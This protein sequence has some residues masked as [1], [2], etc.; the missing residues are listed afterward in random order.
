MQIYHLVAVV[1][2]EHST[3]L[4]S[5]AKVIVHVMDANDQEPL[6]T[7]PELN[8][9][10]LVS[11]RLAVG[12]VISRVRASDNDIGDN[13]RLSYAFYHPDA[14]L[15]FKIDA[16]TGSISI[17]SD[18]TPTVHLNDNATFTVTLTVSDHG[19]PTRRSPHFRHLVLIVTRRPPEVTSP[20]FLGRSSN[21][22][23]V[24]AFVSDGLFVAGAGAIG[25]GLV[26]LTIGLSA[27]W[28]MMRRRRITSRSDRKCTPVT[29]QD[30]E[31]VC[32]YNCRIETLKTIAFKESQT[33]LD[34]HQHQ[35][36]R[37]LQTNNSCYCSRSTA[38]KP[39]IL[40]CFDDDKMTSENN[41]NS[42]GMSSFSTGQYNDDIHGCHGNKRIV[43]GCRGMTSDEQPRSTDF[44]TFPNRQSVS[45]DVY[46][47]LLLQNTCL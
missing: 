47:M 23:T 33:K 26:L 18:L 11:S 43:A 3:T 40:D 21:G 16:D 6:W 36:E 5:T 15:P 30:D 8:T 44:N 37:L 9:T 29:S 25:A 35:H 38:S 12:T 24:A 34:H 31:T 7:S 32:K 10:I 27:V 41:E 19:V 4:T 46:N 2:D 42:S 28:C 45:V 39:D 13:A 20:G 22:G 14:S 1:R 17:I